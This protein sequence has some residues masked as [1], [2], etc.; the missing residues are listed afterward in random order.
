MAKTEKTA[1][2]KQSSEAKIMFGLYCYAED[3]EFSTFFSRK[4]HKLHTL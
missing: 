3:R 2:G 4:R 1:E